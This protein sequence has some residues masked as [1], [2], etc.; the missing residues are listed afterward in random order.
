MSRFSGMRTRLRLLLSRRAAE[1]RMTE[2]I[3][4]HI[5]MEAERLEAEGFSP[6]EARR[7]AL[8]RF[9]GVDRTKEELRAGRGLAWISGLL[10]DV[11]L[12]GRLLL[13]HP[14]LTG[15]SVLALAI[16]LA[17][18]ASWFEFMG[19]LS[20]PDLGLPDGD[21]VVSIRNQDLVAGAADPR[22]LHDF[23]TWRSELETIEDLTAATPAEFNVTTDD[24]RFATV[25]G[26]RVTPSM[27]RIAGVRPLLGRTLVAQDLDAASEPVVLISHSAWERLFDRDPR[28][29]GRT[30][31]LGAQH[32]TVVGVMPEGFEFPVN[33]EMWTPLRDRAVSYDRRQG[34]QLMTFGRLAPG[35]SME[36]ARAE[37]DVIGRRTAAEFPATHE[38]VRPELR[39]YGLI[40]REARFAALLNIPFLLFVLVVSANVAT[41]LFA[42][43]ASRESEIAMRSALGASRRRL[44]LQLVAEACVLT[45]LAAALGTGLAHWGLG[46]G[47]D[48]YWE[49][50]QMRPPYW[51]DSG[52]SVS[53][54]VYATGLALLGAMV[55]GGIPGLRATGRRLRD[56]ITQPGAGGAGMRF[57][58][59]ATTVIVVQ[60]ALCVAFIPV[61]IMNG[62]ALMPERRGD[63]GFPAETY[64]SGKLTRQLD[65]A[66]VGGV[67]G[68]A[69]PGTET[70]ALFDEVRRRLLAERGILAATAASRIPGFNHPT[71]EIEIDGDSTRVIPARVLA[72][73][74][75]FFDVMEARI[76]SGRPFTPD[77]AAATNGVAVLDEDWA[78]AVF[79]GRSPVGRRIRVVDHDDDGGNPWSEIVGVVSGME[80]AGGPGGRIA[81]FQPLHPESHQAIQLYLKTA[82]P[83]ASLA[84]RVHSLVASVDPSLG[85]AGLKPLEEIWRP[86]ER[87]DAFFVVALGIIAGIILLF[88]MIGIYA[89][90][91]FTVGQ[92]EREIGIRS[93][94]GADP[95]RIL[96]SI[97]TRALTQIG[98]GILAGGVLISLT[99]ARSPSEWRLVG[100]VALAMA[101]VGLLGCVVPALRALRIQPTDALRA[102]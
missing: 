22:S 67:P 100:G 17:L 40:S 33:Q 83:P 79:A 26:A 59:V 38:H 70:G 11:R 89:L 35:V 85:M 27:F 87:S 73:D 78:E 24:G 90:M 72:V 62:M 58:P 55:I 74:P 101:A 61:A 18:A 32:A 60:V 69:A 16:A 46:W 68:A 34:P 6:A 10:L 94:L 49:V 41:L 81:V 7:R 63:G 44:V 25:R 43:T 47:M 102:E 80:R 37:L 29:L 28:V 86:V 42:R 8:V 3:A 13:K 50:Q 15:A 98:L 66:A 92:R 53:S 5:D 4:F 56:R 14:V 21:R 12:G 51:F 45:A 93:A 75:D 36:R 76:V 52:L 71:D 19:H 95:R 30:V 57:G 39:R 64:L 2:E 20:R 97:F 77:D 31:R 91:S 65:L 54:V 84:A 48:L 1:S 23:E 99:L 88:A 9:G 82:V 96:A